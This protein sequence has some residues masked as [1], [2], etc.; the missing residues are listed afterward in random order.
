MDS[1]LPLR[2]ELQ[3]GADGRVDFS[4]P[5]PAG[6]KVTVLVADEAQAETLDL[7]AAA[8]SSTEFWDNPYDDE[9]WNHA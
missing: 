1:S 8:A 5:L 7:V 3:V 9:D 6:S 2:F 4:V